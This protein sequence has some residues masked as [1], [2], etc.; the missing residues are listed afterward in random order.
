MNCTDLSCH[1]ALNWPKLKNDKWNQMTIKCQ[2]TGFAESETICLDQVQ[3]LPVTKFSTL[4]N[5]FVLT[6]SSACE[7]S[8]GYTSCDSTHSCLCKWWILTKR[9]SLSLEMSSSS[10]S[11]VTQ[12]TNR[13]GYCSSPFL[14]HIYS[15]SLSFRKFKNLSKNA[16]HLWSPEY[17]AHR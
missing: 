11:E 5:K 17:N 14:M 4:L 10:R 8:K 13:H 16:K 12:R 3:I 6:E 15:S 2:M 1:A 9:P 7:I